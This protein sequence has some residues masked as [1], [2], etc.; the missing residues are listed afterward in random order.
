MTVT[1][2]PPI[3]FNKDTTEEIKEGE[4]ED[5]KIVEPKKRMKK[6]LIH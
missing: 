2:T 3:I 1:K 5:E 4:E 6:K